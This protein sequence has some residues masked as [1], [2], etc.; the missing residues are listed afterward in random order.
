MLKIVEIF[1]EP[2]FNSGKAVE[3][4]H[5]IKNSTVDESFAATITDTC[6]E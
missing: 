6:V 2:F 5:S 4:I 3:L 1:M